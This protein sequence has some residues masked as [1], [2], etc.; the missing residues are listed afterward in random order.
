MKVLVATVGLSLLAAAAYAQAP[1]ERTI[2]EIKI[3][4]QARA[5][6]GGHAPRKALAFA[7]AICP[8]EKVQL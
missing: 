7:V 3:E 6:R 8:M 4:A 1:R 5:E 2:E